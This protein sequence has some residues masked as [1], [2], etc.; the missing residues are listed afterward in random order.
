MRKSINQEKLEKLK[1]AKNWFNSLPVSMRQQ[2]TESVFTSCT[3]WNVLSD[4]DILEIS[5]VAR[6]KYTPHQKK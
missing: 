2:L 5:N 6:I 3:G 4:E 1:E